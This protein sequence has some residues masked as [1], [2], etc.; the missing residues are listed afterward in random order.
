MTCSR[1][2]GLDLH[3]QFIQATT[4][5]PDGRVLRE[6]RFTTTPEEIRA[7]AAT[8]TAEDAVALES[9]TNAIAVA[10]LLREH[11]GRVVVSNPMKT[12]AIAEAKVKTDKVDALVLAQLLRADYLPEVWVPDDQTLRL[13]ELT[14]YRTGLVRER[15]E[16]K[17]RIHSIL[18]RNLIPRPECRDLFG[19]AGRAYL[20]GLTDLP[21]GEAFQ[22]EQALLHLDFLEQ[23]I[24]TA[25][26]EVAKLAV[27]SPD[28]RLLLSLPG[29][30]L[31]VA[32][33]VLAA[34]GDFTRFAEPRKLVSY[35]GLDPLA[36]SSADQ[37]F[38]SRRISKKGRSHARWLMIEAATAAVRVPGPLQ[39]FYL[40]LRAKK[41]HNKAVCA[42]ARKMLHFLWHMLASGEPY[43]YAPP[44]QTREKIRIVE[45]LAGR[46]KP[47]ARARQPLTYREQRRH[48]HDLAKAAQ[49][50]YEE[51]VRLRAQL[52][53]TRE[54]GRPDD[55]ERSGSG[56]RRQGQVRSADGPACPEPDRRAALDPAA[57]RSQD[58]PASGRTKNAAP[59]HSQTRNLGPAT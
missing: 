49:A 44:I 9:T 17:N 23:R 55:G 36:K 31:Q 4:I 19:K 7:Y 22:L 41:C 42:V 54:T 32:A 38:G 14:S 40:R 28:T 27:E 46:P 3:K 15:T 50:Q 16:V 5:D 2:T 48:Q 47:N 12:R 33:G 35:F 25:D 57:P 52:D 24:D 56:P 51:L 39:A 34:I 45:R 11:A 10:V 26:R 18:H 21:R 13:R 53:E 29:V 59:A 6:W 8:L 43:R 30:S 37:V 20:D 58:L 1:F